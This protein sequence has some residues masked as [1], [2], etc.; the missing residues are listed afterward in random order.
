MLKDALRNS[1]VKL[2]TR[3]LN[4]AHCPIFLL[5][6]VI[7]EPGP[8]FQDHFDSLEPE[9]FSKQLQHLQ[10]HLEFI[11]LAKAIELA[12]LG[13]S[14]RGKCVLSFDDGYSC[15]PEYAFPVLEELKIPATVFIVSSIIDDQSMF[16]RDYVRYI[17]QNNLS[18]VFYDF[19]EGS[20]A[21]THLSRPEKDVSFKKWSR[22][23]KGHNS[24]DIQSA[25]VTFFDKNKIEILNDDQN[26]GSSFYMSL[27]QLK[28]APKNITFGNHTHSHA[29]LPSLSPQE[30]EQEILKCKTFLDQL[31]NKEPVFCLPFGSYNS[32]TIEVIKSCGYQNIVYHSGVGKN[33]QQSLSSGKID[34]YSLTGHSD[35]LT[36]QL[37]KTALL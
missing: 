37:L 33:T 13:K 31:N 9:V 35:E 2:G 3:F 24:H 5:H 16:W 11:S 4:Y 15:L 29:V 14:L 30:Q 21:F 10:N 20:D 34:R 22:D 17:E 12:G 8:F 19:C 25:L 1:A 23:P 27:S 18:S 26:S 7:Q 6:G 36:L 28:N 32:K